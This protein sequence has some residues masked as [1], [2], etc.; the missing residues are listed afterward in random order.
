LLGKTYR[1]SQLTY[2]KLV[3]TFLKKFKKMR[4]GETWRNGE[5]DETDETGLQ[6]SPY[7]Y[8]AFSR[9]SPLKF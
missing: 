9:V 2:E 8:T 5:T 4:N 6:V 3:E 7:F 1:F